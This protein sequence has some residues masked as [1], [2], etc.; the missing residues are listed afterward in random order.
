MNLYFRTQLN[1]IVAIDYTGSNGDPRDPK[2]LHY[3]D[4]VHQNNQ[5][6]N[7]IRAVGDIVQE[8]D[9][10]K[11]F[12]AY[13]FGAKLPNGQVDF[14]FNVNLTPNPDCNMIDGVLYAYR[15][16]LPQLQLWGPTNFSPIIR[17]AALHARSRQDGSAYTVLLILTD[18]AI[19]DF[20][21]TKHEIVQASDLPMSII[22]VGVGNADFDA[23]D[24]LDGDGKLLKSPINGQ[25]AS[26]DIVQFVPFRKFL[27][28]SSGP[29]DFGM[30]NSRLAKEV[31][32]EVPHQFETWMLKRGIQPIG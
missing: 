20:N 18:G 26:R 8:Y 25:R 23:M 14:C 4:P 5:Y 11:Q 27:G 13:G 17:Q 19:T 28:L 15:S 12:P 9:S 29:S 16:T 31:L 22:I 21:E 2:S 1:F 7:A 10:D 6:T 24:E 30:S 32:Q 3:F